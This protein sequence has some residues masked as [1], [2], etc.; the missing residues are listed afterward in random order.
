MMAKIK[1]NP[2]TSKHGDVREV[3]VSERDIETGDLLDI[4]GREEY[5]VRLGENIAVTIRKNGWG[6]VESAYEMIRR[7]NEIHLQKLAREKKYMNGVHP[8]YEKILEGIAA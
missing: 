1:F 3:A 7:V 8:K 5:V 4:C 2:R 6:I